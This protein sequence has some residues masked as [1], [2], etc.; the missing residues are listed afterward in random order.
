MTTGPQ[1]V[2]IINNANGNTTNDAADMIHAGD[3]FHTP[4]RGITLR[5][6]E[7][8]VIDPTTI[9]NGVKIT[10]A[11]LDGSFGQ[12]NDVVIT[13]GYV[14]IENSTREVV[15]RFADTL[16]DDTYRVTIIGAGLTPL[17]DSLGNA[18]NSGVNQS[19]DFK[20]D[21]GAK[22][23]AVVPQPITRAANVLSQSANTVEVYFNQDTLNQA[24]AENPIFYRLTDQAT[25]TV[26]NPTGVTYSSANN[27]AILT[28]GITLNGNYKLSIGT[29]TGNFFTTYTNTAAGSDINSS[30]ATAQDIGTVGVVGQSING[31]ITG[32][33]NTIAWPGAGDD[34]GHRDI[35]FESHLNGGPDT[36]GG[37]STFFYNFRDNYGSDPN[38]N[39]LHNLI[40]ETQKQRAREIFELY[41]RYLGIQFVES[42]AGGAIIATGDLRAIDPSAPIN[43]AGGLAGGGKAVMNGNTNWGESEYGGAWF[44]T[45]MHEIGHLLGLGHAY[46]LPDLT[47]Q[48]GSET[49]GA[50]SGTEPV[51]PG[52]ADVIHGQTLDRPDS[53]DIDI[54][55][56]TVTEKGRF[57]ARP[58]QSGWSIPA[59]S[60][61]Y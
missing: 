24:S 22:V 28:F 26:V 46:D 52:T 55:K 51:F 20:L 19:V 34:P 32:Q 7:G 61:P 39:P 60:T 45:A 16:P 37:S 30:F 59:C 44:T 2:A 33:P 53:R 10:R 27:R 48:G 15:I 43:G 3:I 38:G 31:A 41:S 21:L 54:Y 35:P 50:P 8:Q 14:G 1:L 40:T 18:F 42:A 6:G 58:L 25:G 23:V 56:F 4:P 12:P 29:N 9:A 13:P 57:R 47:I 17:K 11:G 36:T 49:P 5:F